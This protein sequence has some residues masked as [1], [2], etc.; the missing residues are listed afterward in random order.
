[1]IAANLGIKIPPKSKEQREYDR[2]VREKEMRR[3]N[4]EREAARRAE[5]EKEKAKRS[6]WED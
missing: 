5:E 3:K 1:M 2:A 4:E 6:V